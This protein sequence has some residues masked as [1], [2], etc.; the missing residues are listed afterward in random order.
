MT[1]TIN[2]FSIPVPFTFSWYADR[3]TPGSGGG[4]YKFQTNAVINISIPGNE[5]E[6]IRGLESALYVDDPEYFI[7][8]STEPFYLYGKAY[9]TTYSFYNAKIK[10]ITCSSES[11]DV[12]MVSS[13]VQREIE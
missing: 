7:I 9:K 13:T 11:F 10:R 5:I 4:N 2:E 6:S 12:E 3:V 1:V 8:A